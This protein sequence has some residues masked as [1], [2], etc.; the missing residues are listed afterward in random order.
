MS[1]SPFDPPADP[2]PGLADLDVPFAPE[3]DLW[4]GIAARI[5][6]GRRRKPWPMAV[7]AGLLAAVA[8]GLMWPDPGSVRVAADAPTLTVHSLA[9]RPPNALTGRAGFAGDA[10]VQP[11]VQANLQIVDDAQRQLRQAL[12]SE[13]DADYL[14]G[15]LKRTEQRSRELQALL[16]SET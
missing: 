10:T 13:P 6:S 14:R 7:A 3:R 1:Q 15:L 16:S 8:L 9:G 11:L 5:E 4:P 2:I 12:R